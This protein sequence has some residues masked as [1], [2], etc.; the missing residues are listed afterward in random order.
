M[1]EVDILRE[2]ALKCKNERKMALLGGKGLKR[3]GCYLARA[4]QQL[5][6][7]HFFEYFGL[8]DPHCSH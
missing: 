7:K 4:G 3:I 5:S 2:I 6:F 8:I 1:K